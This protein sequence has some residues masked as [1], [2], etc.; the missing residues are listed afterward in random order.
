MRVLES[1]QGVR[2]VM[3][4][5]FVATGSPTTFYAVGPLATAVRNAGHEVILAAHQPWIETV[6]GIGLPTACFSPEPIRHYMKPT[7]PGP[8]IFL[9]NL[10]EETIEVGRGFAKMTAVALP[11]LL[12]LTKDWRPDLIVG[13]SVSYAAGLLAHR[14]NVP[15]VRL[16]EFLAIPLADLDP[17]A[18]EGL[19][20]ELKSLG[21][22][23]L[24]EP[25]LFVDVTPP[26]LMMPYDP[27]AE[28]MRWVSAYPQR[29]LEP[30]MYTRPKDRHRV[31]ITTEVRTPR[32]SMRRLVDELTQDGAEVL[33][34]APDEVAR[35]FGADVGAAYVGWMPLDVVAPTCDLVVHCAGAAI[36]MTFMAAGVPQLIIPPNNHT[37]AIAQAMYDYGASV[38]VMLLE[39]TPAED[40]ADAIIA[41]CRE[42]FARPAYAQRSQALAAQMAALPDPATMVRTLEMLAD[43]QAGGPGRGALLTAAS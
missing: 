31:L 9:K 5:L 30:W 4:F 10:R 40:L 38:M 24:P 12:D 39:Q 43:T 14:I 33:I 42:I 34:E 25:A 29:R 16:A 32:W 41:G 7:R 11:A 36:A 27:N 15:Y 6:E 1:R 28:A 18:E 2:A 23:R 37:Q 17:G 22:A 26:S 35:A 19:A 8:R 13:S 3:K 21:L 20:P